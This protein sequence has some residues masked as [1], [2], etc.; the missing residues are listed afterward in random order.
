MEKPLDL[1]KSIAGGF[2][3]ESLDE[4]ELRILRDNIERKID[5]DILLKNGFKK[6]KKY[7]NV[8]VLHYSNLRRKIQWSVCVDFDMCNISISSHCM[9]FTNTYHYEFHGTIDYV[10]ELQAIMRIFK[11]DKEITV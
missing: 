7:E 8:F 11:I 4:S 6:V 2:Y 5:Q 9:K 10:G 3:A 1:L